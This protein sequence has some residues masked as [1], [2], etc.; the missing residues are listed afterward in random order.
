VIVVPEGT[1]AMLVR[2]GWAE[3]VNDVNDQHR[4]SDELA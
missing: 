4:K 1:A 2:E 3:L